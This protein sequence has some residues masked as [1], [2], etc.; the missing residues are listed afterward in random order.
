MTEIRHGNW[1]DAFYASS[2]TCLNRK[3]PGEC[4]APGAHLGHTCG[5]QH[6]GLEDGEACK[7]VKVTC[8]IHEPRIHRDL[9][10]EDRMRRA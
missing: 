8:Q 1:G 6:E 2:L 9:E 7:A 3:Q 10:Q 4:V 5:I